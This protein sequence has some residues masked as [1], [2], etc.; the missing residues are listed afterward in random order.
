MSPLAPAP[1]LVSRGSPVRA[2]LHPRCANL[3]AVRARGSRV[4]ARASASGGGEESPLEDKTEVKVRIFKG[5]I[6]CPRLVP[7]LLSRACVAVRR[8][9]ATRDHETGT[10][11]PE[12]VAGADDITFH[13]GAERASRGPA[14]GYGEIHARHA[15]RVLDIR[16]EIPRTSASADPAAPRPDRPPPRPPPPLQL[17]L[18]SI[19]PAGTFADE[20]TSTE[21]KTQMA[22][23]VPEGLEGLSL[24]DKGEFPADSAMPPP[25]RPWALPSP[26]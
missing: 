4:V 14:R 9:P 7:P 17:D 21:A 3:H 1:G 25:P 10:W 13:P 20:S 18:S 5:A 2:S 6:R 19:M 11:D 12:R 24:N 15:P 22:K 8:V 23:G 26:P 16:V